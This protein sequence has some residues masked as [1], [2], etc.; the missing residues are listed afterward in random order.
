M[1]DEKRVSPQKR[2]KCAC[3]SWTTAR[4]CMVIR[5]APDDMERHS[6]PYIEGCEC[7]CHEYDED[8]DA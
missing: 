7:A 1:S 4:E 2:W 8:A 3:P 5:L 6:E